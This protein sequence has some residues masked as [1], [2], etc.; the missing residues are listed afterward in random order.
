MS[1]GTTYSFK[2]LVGALTNPI[3]GVAFPL[4]GGNLGFG[5][6]TIT[7]ATERTTHDVAADGTVMPSYVAGDNGDVAV[8]VQ[9]TSPLH[10]LLLSLYN[11]CVTAANNDDV[12]GWAST[13]IA[14]RTLL[15]GSTHIASGISFAKIPDKP[16][17]ASGQKITW[18]LMA[19]NII[20]M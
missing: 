10:H 6:L 18:R 9:Q 20:N 11:Q 12:S 8:E 7:M 5:A 19:A 3:F 4:S 13:T 1:L 14:F 2:D 16:Y 17:Q 15:D